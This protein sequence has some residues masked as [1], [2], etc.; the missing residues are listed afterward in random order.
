MDPP[1]GGCGCPAEPTQRGRGRREFRDRASEQRV[2][3][4]AGEHVQAEQRG[5]LLAHSHA[6][7]AV[8]VGVQARRPHRHAS[9]SGHGHGDPAAHPALGRQPHVVGPLPGG[10]VHAARVHHAQHVPD[11]VARQHAVSGHGIHAAVGQGGRHHRQVAAGDLDRALL[12]VEVEDG[13]HV[14]VDHVQAAHE[15]RGGPVAIGSP[16]LG[17]QRP[18]VHLQA[19][20]ARVQPEHRED[21]LELVLG[22]RS[23]HQ[24]G[25]D[26][27]PRVDHRVV[28][29]VLALVELDRVERVPAGLDPDPLEH[30]VAAPVGQGQAVHEDFGDGLQREGRL[31]VARAVHVAVGRDQR[32]AEPVGL[33]PGLVEPVVAAG[34]V[35][36]GVH[37][38]GL[39]LQVAGVQ[40]GQPLLDPL[41][42]LG[43]HDARDTLTRLRVGCRTQT[44]D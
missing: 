5:D 28:G 12:E 10:V 27:R 26:Q 37:R 8:A 11:P 42:D 4:I 22:A 3:V 30:V 36:E 6:T 16:A 40:R 34:G 43:A 31:G 20:V 14:A 29:T 38:P 24:V 21:A 25:G 18:L 23:A 35:V 1:S 44:G 41:V 15:V 33:V 32:D 2:L 19:L 39:E 17:V 9:L 13:L 7:R